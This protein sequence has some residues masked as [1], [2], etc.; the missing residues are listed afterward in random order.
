[1]STGEENNSRSIRLCIDGTRAEFADH[2]E[3]ARALYWQAWESSKTDYEACVAAHYV[4]R[5][6]DNLQDNLRWNLEA[7]ARAAA[8]GDERVQAFYPSLYI[9]L[10]RSYELLGDQ[11]QAEKYYALA[12]SLGLTHEPGN[13][14]QGRLA[15]AAHSQGNP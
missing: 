5:F 6:Q 12:S 13:H 14:M 9:N 11:V 3:Q 10:G 7:L 8:V 4:A 1:M 15:R 2:P